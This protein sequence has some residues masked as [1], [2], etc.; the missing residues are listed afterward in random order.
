MV[1][2]VF[3]DESGDEGSVIVEDVRQVQKRDVKKKKKEVEKVEYRK[4]NIKVG[5]RIVDYIKILVFVKFKDDNIEVVKNKRNMGLKGKVVKLFEMKIKVVKEEV[6][7]VRKRREKVEK[8]LLKI[9]KRIFFKSKWDSIMSQIDVEKNVVKFKV[10]VKSKLESYFSI[11]L[12][13]IVKKEVVI[14][15]KFKKKLFS[16]FI[17]DFSK[18]K[19]KLNFG[20]LVFVIRREL[21]FVISKKNFFRSNFIGDVVKRLFFVVFNGS[22]N[23]FKL[24]LNDFVGSSL[25]GFVISFVRSSY[26]D[27]V[28]ID[29]GGEFS[30]LGIFRI[31]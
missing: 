25:F 14:K 16:L 9:I 12:L 5:F 2:E 22:F 1:K 30:V 10:E 23:V 7:E 6:V 19:S 18:V 3:E 24:D 28:G 8:E 20:F 31:V 17:L 15:E 27:L 21:F 13:F 11:F 26:S 4:F 29:G